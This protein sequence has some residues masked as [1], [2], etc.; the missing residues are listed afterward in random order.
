VSYEQ[1]IHEYLGH[2]KKDRVL[3]V[4]WTGQVPHEAEKHHGNSKV[5]RRFKKIQEKQQFRRSTAEEVN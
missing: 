3:A 4:V 1:E 5:A 2:S